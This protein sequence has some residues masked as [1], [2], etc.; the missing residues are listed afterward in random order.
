MNKKISIGI[1]V[2]VICVLVIAAGA[3]WFSQKSSTSSDEAGVLYDQKS[4]DSDIADLEEMNADTS[5]Q[6][7][8]G[9][10][11]S[12]AGEGAQTSSTT[13]ETQA[14]NGTPSNSAQGVDIA[15]ITNLESEL[16]LELN[17]FSTDLNDLQGVESDPSLTAFDSDLSQVAQ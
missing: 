8:D 4:L 9:D 14:S 5:L 12:V 7:L 10:L 3:Y 16:E 11:A 1:G 2:G 13:S 17:S 6:N 15:S